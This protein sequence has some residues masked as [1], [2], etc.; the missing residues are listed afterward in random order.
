MFGESRITTVAFHVCFA[1]GYYDNRGDEAF[2]ENSNGDGFLAE[3]VVNGICLN[4]QSMQVSVPS[5]CGQE[6]LQPPR[7]MLQHLVTSKT[8]QGVQ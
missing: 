8:R 3:I 2:D 1:V 4:Q 5:I 6:L 7:G